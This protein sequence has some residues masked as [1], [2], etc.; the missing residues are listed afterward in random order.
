MADALPSELL[1]QRSSW[2]SGGGCV[3]VALPDDRAVVRHSRD[4]TREPLVFDKREWLRF[5]SCV[6]DG[7]FDL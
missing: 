5:V 1:F 2:C 6:K 4:R 7:G 3:E